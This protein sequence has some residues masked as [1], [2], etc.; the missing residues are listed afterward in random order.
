MKAL[1]AVLILALAVPAAAQ[2]KSKKDDKKQAPAPA[3]SSPDQLMREAEQKA[4][5]GD[6]DGAAELLRRAVAMPAATGEPSMRLGRLLEG[7]Y[8]FDAAIDAYKV[9]GDK[10]TG[11]AKGEALGRMAV[12]QQV[13]GMPEASATAQA[14]AAA[15]PQGVWPAIAQARALAREGKGDEAVALAQK[16]AATGARRRRARSAT[17]RRPRETSPLR[18]PPTAPRS[19]TPSRRRSPASASPASCARR[20]ARGRP[21]PS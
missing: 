7:K 8:E 10:L 6:K 4:A 20:A 9:A 5:A 3:A 11:A 18:R 12:L 19:T 14:A 1:M 17:P 16:V 2:E 21:S 13:R 15:D